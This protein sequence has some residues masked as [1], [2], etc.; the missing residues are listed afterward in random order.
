MRISPHFVP[1]SFIFFFYFIEKSKHVYN[2]EQFSVET[3]TKS[4][5]IS[6]AFVFLLLR[7]SSITIFFSQLG[8]GRKKA[9]HVCSLNTISTN[10]L[11]ESNAVCFFSKVKMA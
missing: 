10:P 11:N 5:K 9:N 6:I 7:L 1:R 3:D 8:Y 4:I 2:V